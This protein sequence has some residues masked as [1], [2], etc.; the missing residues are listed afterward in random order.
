MRCVR[1]DVPNPTVTYPYVLDGAIIVSKDG[2]SG[3]AGP[4]HVNWTSSTIPTHN[5]TGADN[6]LA[7]KFQVAKE[8]CN[9]TNV[10]GVTPDYSTDNYYWANAVAA[11][12][13]YT[14]TGTTHETTAGNWRL[15][16]RAELELIYAEKGK[17]TGV[18]DFT[19]TLFGTPQVSATESNQNSARV[20]SI[21]FDDGRVYSFEKA[22]EY[23]VR[24]VRDI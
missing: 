4:F 14:Q 12:A 9:S 5:E 2:Y 23:F 3:T 24:C 15:P 8:D 7:E 6:A 21:D 13:A 20:W 19:I 18:D 16:T 17:L 11:C 10:P 1:D 22:S